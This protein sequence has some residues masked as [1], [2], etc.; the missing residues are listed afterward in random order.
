MEHQMFDTSLSP[1][2]LT[3]T[4][5]RCLKVDLVPMV[6]GQPAIGKSDIIRSVA[7]QLNLKLVDFRLS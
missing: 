7:K 4:L 3:E 5:I 1:S 6:R 2:E